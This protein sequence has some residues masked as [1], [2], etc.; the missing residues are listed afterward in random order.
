MRAVQSHEVFVG[1]IVS[2]AH[3]PRGGYGFT[4]PVDA[5][6]IALNLDG[7]RAKIEVMKRNGDV[8]TRHVDTTN[9]R[10]KD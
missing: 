10:W 7:T 2:W 9:L 8:V 5:K 4:Y 6:V 3:V 1:A